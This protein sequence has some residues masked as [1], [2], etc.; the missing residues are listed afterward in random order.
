MKVYYVNANKVNLVEKEV[1]EFVAM[2]SNVSIA[3]I[4]ELNMA[5][6]CMKTFEL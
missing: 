1:K 4:N 2:F 5:T 6:T 3:M